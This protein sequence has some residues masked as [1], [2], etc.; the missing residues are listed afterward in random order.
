MWP[1][2]SSHSNSAKTKLGKK[3]LTLTVHMV[4]SM[5]TPQLYEQTLTCR[6][7]L[8]ASNRRSFIRDS[9]T[10]CIFLRYCWCWSQ[11]RNEKWL[12]RI[13]LL[14][15]WQTTQHIATTSCDHLLSSLSLVFFKGSHFLNSA[16]SIWAL[17]NWGKGFLSVYVNACWDGLGQLFS[18]FKWGIRTKDGLGILF[19]DNLAS[20]KG[21]LLLF[22]RK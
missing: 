17:S 11:N 6:L 21:N 1:G 19:S 13:G 9:K 2:V 22:F 16:P 4:H 8:Y 10:K 15:S 20:S 18:T 7:T 5:R 14:I 12:T 3:V